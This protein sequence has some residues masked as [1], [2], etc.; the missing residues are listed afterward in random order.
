MKDLLDKRLLWVGGKGGVGKTTVAASLAVLAARRERRVLVVS[1]DPAHSLG[2]VFDR[3][4][5][6]VPRRLLPNLD[7]MEIDPDAEV[8]AHLTRVTEQMRRF[9]A[10]QMMAELERQMRLTRQSPGTQEAALLERLSRLITAEDP[11]HD[12][13]IFD[14][15]PTGH[16]LRLLS[17]PEAMAA[18]TDGLLAHNR[19]SEE[20]G[21]VLS[22]LTP[23]RGR[24]VATPFDDPQEDPLSGLDERTRDVARTLIER[25]RLFHQARRRVEDPECTG[26]LFVLTPERLPILETARAVAALEAVK[27]PVAGTLVNRVIP[28]EADGDFLRARRTQEA[29]YLARIDAELGHLPR[30]RL[31][32]LPTDVQGLATLEE[33]ADRLEAIGF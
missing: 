16:T 21:K 20:L 25:R 6:D 30:P 13:I 7:A 14:T 15:A 12:L 18:W 29:S 17:L 31:P 26:F 4:L 27:I 24:D 5:G 10:P 1:T 9:A 3:Q 23:K 32:W 28:D 33:L 8:E 22:H 2:D 19:K 11:E